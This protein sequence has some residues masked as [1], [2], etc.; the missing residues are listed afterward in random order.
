MTSG[1]G[2]SQGLPLLGGYPAKRCPRRVHNAFDRSVP[3]PPPAPESLLRRMDEGRA[4]E[5]EVVVPLLEVALGDNCVSIAYGDHALDKE[6]R[7][8]ETLAAIGDRTLVIVGGQ[9]PDDTAGGRT[10]SPDVL[11]RFTSEFGRATYVPADIKHHTT[12][13]RAR[14]GNARVTALNR[15]LDQTIPYPA[16]GWSHMTS[17][18]FEDAMQLAHYTRML[19]AIDRHPGTKPKSDVFLGGIIGTTDFTDLTGERY[20]VVWY[21]LEVLTE[22]TP[23]TSSATGWAKRSVLE[24]Y[25]HEFAFRQ[26]VAEVALAGGPALVQP[27]GKPECALCPY[28]EW[29]NNAAG[30]DD[31]SFAITTGRLSDREWRYLYD[32]GLSTVEALAHADPAGLLLDGFRRKAAHLPTPKRRLTTAIRRAQ[33]IRDQ[34]LLE[35]TT[36]GPLQ[37]PEAD[38]EIDFDVEWHPADAHV[39]QWGARVRHG[40]DD[41]TATYEHSVMSFETL[42]DAKAQALADDFFG[43]LEAF[44]GSHERAGRTVRVFHWTSPEVTR[45]IRMLGRE[46]AE[47]LFE[48]FFDLRQWMDEQFFARDGLSLKV[49]APIFGFEWKVDGAGGEMSVRK[50]EEARDTTNPLTSHEAKAWLSSYNEDDCAAQAAIRDGLRSWA[51][52]DRITEGLQASQPDPADLGVEPFVEDVE[53][54]GSGAGPNELPTSQAKPSAPSGSLAP[55]KTDDRGIQIQPRKLPMPAGKAL[56]LNEIRS[57]VDAFVAEWRDETSENSESQSFWNDFFNCFGISRRRVATFERWATRATTGAKGRIDVFWPGVLIAEQKSAGAMR[58]DSAEQ[59]ANDYLVGGD[60]KANEYPRYII[61][62]DFRTIRLT[63]LEAQNSNQTVTFPLTDLSKRLEDFAWIAGYQPRKFST[64]EETAASVKA[65]SLMANLYVALTGDADEDLVEDAKDESDQSLVVSVMM[66]RLLFLMFGDDAGLWEKGL[67]NDFLMNRT[68]A[69]G[70]DLG[71]QLNALFDVINTR[72]HR[73]SSKTDAAMLAF[74][75]VNG[76]LFGGRDVTQFF[77]SKMR[78]AVIQASAFEWTAISPAV[79]GSLFQ[80]IKSKAARR[81]DGEHYTTETN[82]LKTLEPLFLDDIRADLRKA[83]KSPKKLRDLH[84]TFATKRYM[85]PACGCGNFLIVA[86]REMR[87]I[88]LDLL[89]RLRQLDGDE[90]AM[91]LDGTWDLNVSLDQFHGIEINWWP[92][93]IAET[94][95]FLVDHQANREMAL[96]LGQAPDRLPIKITAHIVHGNALTTDWAAVLPPTAD[97]YVFGNPPFLGH[98]SRTG[99]QT[100]LLRAAWGGKDIGRLDFVTGWYAK[101]IKYFGRVNGQWAFVSTSS[102]AQGDQVP[103]LFGPVFDAGWKIKFAH[104]TFAWSSE[105]TGK[106]AVHCTII[107]FSRTPTSPRLFEYSTPRSEAHEITTGAINA[108]LVDGPNVLVEARQTPLADDLSEVTFGN[109]PRDGGYLIVT[110][111]DYDSVMADLIASKY[112]RPF[113]GSEELLHNKMRWCLWLTEL[114]PADIAKSPVLKERIEGVKAIRL[115]SKAPSTRGM[116][117]TPALFGQRPAQ[118]TEPYLGIPRVVSDSRRYYPATRL[119]ANVVPSDRLFTA[120][121]PDGL[122]FAIICSSMFI[123]WQKTVGNRP[124]SDPSFS[125]TL[126]W[127]NLPLPALSGGTRAK[128]IAAGEAIQT[129]RNLHPKRSLADHYN[130][131]AMDPALISAHNK[132][133]ALVDRA[134][135]SAKICANERE[136]Q[137]VLFARYQELTK[138]VGEVAMP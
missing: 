79:F 63:D 115:A 7:I 60:I 120:P 107:G 42:D 44:V 105:A 84:A 46:R 77:D 18:R 76:A 87:R 1:K 38:F 104:R 99:E 52:L 113:L 134:F 8:D 96:A 90:A 102:V 58:D 80:A 50:I 103:R 83:W 66:T 21:D 27:F 94:A 68:E 112:V 59:Q 72:E 78:D 6:R 12:L 121:D 37:V 137:A 30:K 24:V 5:R 93:K 69:D 64:A 95:M 92:A 82:I 97:T 28:E 47:S 3:A 127:N 124:K 129:A 61:T 62:S 56:S 57:R 122:L 13:R 125:N 65:A 41:S 117:A 54:A 131:L 109:M 71:S 33:M 49:V 29:C 73:R 85:D 74:P 55:T 81:V 89:V 111:E 130:P 75:Y 88:E 45:T 119:Q 53:Q 14:L 32:Q 43:W 118:L 128:I 16:P 36:R 40:Q 108:Y 133:D 9:L 22:K 2:E 132:L 106:A 25:D 101:A 17:H 138:S 126:V 70:S 114:D 116:A 31:A 91:T 98:I 67:F 123:T 15:T 39:Y 51:A 34:V 135:G 35:R 136:R 110:P 10:G 19:Q 4:F 11:F 26:Q 23:S 48:R 86:Y 20:G 100:E